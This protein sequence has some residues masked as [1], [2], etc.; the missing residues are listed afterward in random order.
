MKNEN[1]LAS[2]QNRR[3]FIIFFQRIWKVNRILLED[4]IIFYYAFII[5]KLRE[6]EN[7][8]KCNL[9]FPLNINII[10][11]LFPFIKWAV[12]F[13]ETVEYELVEVINYFIN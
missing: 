3:G 7:K 11:N 2:I 6:K 13:S 12:T 9:V 4:I 5:L 10:R 1:A 8:R